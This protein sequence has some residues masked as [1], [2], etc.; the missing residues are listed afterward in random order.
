MQ[1]S[2]PDQAVT[3]DPVP[4]VFLHIQMHG[5]GSGL[6]DIVQ[7]FVVAA[8]RSFIGNITESRDG[9]DLF[10][11]QFDGIIQE[12]DTHKTET[13][14]TDFHDSQPG[15]ANGKIAHGMIVGSSV[16]SVDIAHRF[17]DRLAKT[18]ADGNRLVRRWHSGYY[19]ETAL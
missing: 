4:K 8:E 14:I 3:F 13:G 15:Q 12:V 17:T 11:L 16:C 1:I 5:V 9:T 10:Q 6:P 18:D 19:L 2:Y 7:T